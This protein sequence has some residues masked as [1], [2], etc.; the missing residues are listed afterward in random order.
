MRSIVDAENALKVEVGEMKTAVADPFTR[1]HC[2]PTLVTRV[3]YK[4]QT[5]SHLRLSIYCRP[6]LIIRVKIY[7]ADLLLL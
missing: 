7:T 3:S 4:L 6:I 2:R 1:R 5:Y